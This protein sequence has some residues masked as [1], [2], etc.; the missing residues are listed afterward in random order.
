MFKATPSF[1][2]TAL[3]RSWWRVASLT[4]S[5]LFPVT[6]RCILRHQRLF[7]HPHFLPFQLLSLVGFFFYLD[8]NLNSQTPDRQTGNEINKSWHEEDGGVTAFP[9]SVSGWRCRSVC[10]RRGRSWTAAFPPHAAGI[11]HRLMKRQLAP[12]LLCVCTCV[13]NL[14]CCRTTGLRS[15]F[16][17]HRSSFR[18][19]NLD[20][21]WVEGWVKLS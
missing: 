6:H 2:H 20:V 10:W 13:S 4:A 15:S 7:I 11:T 3:Y 16:S 17:V 9:L 18:L 14:M 19:P 8:N 21:F 5:C 1:K 12:R